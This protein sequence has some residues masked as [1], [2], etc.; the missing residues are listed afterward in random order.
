VSSISL[1]LSFMAASFEE[2]VPAFARTISS[3][4]CHSHNRDN[5]PVTITCRYICVSCR[6]QLDD[7]ILGGRWGLNIVSGYLSK[8]MA[9]FGF[10]EPTADVD[11]IVKKTSQTASQP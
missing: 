3:S 5:A 2:F 9:A 11:S 4:L 7:H 8:E 1:M 6:A 10:R